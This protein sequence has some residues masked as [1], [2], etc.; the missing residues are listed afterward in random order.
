LTGRI[1]LD[2]TVVIDLLRRRPATTAR[3]RGLAREHVTPYV[4]AVTVE[5]ASA[6]LRP[7]EREAAGSLFEALVE[8]PLGIAEGRMA[9]WWRSRARRSG[10][11]LSQADAL[12]AASAASLDAA[13]AT[14]NAKDFPMAEIRVEHWPVGE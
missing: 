7:G 4:C 12:I 3:F 13:L 14:G 9:G 5:E 10:L 2:T 8:A 1:V 6:W 11:T